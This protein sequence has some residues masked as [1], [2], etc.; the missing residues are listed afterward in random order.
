MT[1]PPARIL[2]SLTRMIFSPT[3][4]NV[5]YRWQRRRGLGCLVPAHGGRC[6][7][8]FALRDDRDVKYQMAIYARCLGLRLEIH[9]AQYGARHG[10][11]VT[12][13]ERL[14]KSSLGK[15]SRDLDDALSLIHSWM[16]EHGASLVREDVRP[17]G[18]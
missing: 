7:A 12:E 8:T 11:I 5:V 16:A 4:R 2:P 10:C 14:T 13:K 17:I 15:L 18:A 3:I 1:L 9:V 6:Q